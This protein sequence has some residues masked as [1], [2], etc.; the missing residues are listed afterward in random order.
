MLLKNA[1]VHDG[2]GRVAVLDILVEEGKIARVA[3]PG[4]LPGEGIDLTG[5]HI[6]PGFVQPISA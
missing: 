4:S 5:K 3:Q 6:L 1:T 2:L